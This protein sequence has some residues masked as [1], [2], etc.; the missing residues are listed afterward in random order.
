MFCIRST[1][2]VDF[3]LSVIFFGYTSRFIPLNLAPAYLSEFSKFVLFLYLSLEVS[4]RFDLSYDMV[5]W[6][7]EGN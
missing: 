5:E 1:V 2:L 7:A 4:M 3:F 6:L